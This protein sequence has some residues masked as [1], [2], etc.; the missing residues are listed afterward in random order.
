MEDDSFLE[1]AGVSVTNYGRIYYYHLLVS[2]ITDEIKVSNANI[3]ITF[4]D[5]CV[6]PKK[7]LYKFLYG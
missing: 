4:V 3:V 5:L 6:I 1:Y 2:I 7:D